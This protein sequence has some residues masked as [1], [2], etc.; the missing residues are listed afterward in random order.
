MCAQTLL[1]LNFYSSW[2][3]MTKP[4]HPVCISSQVFV[5]LSHL[6]FTLHVSLQGLWIFVSLPDSINC[7]DCDLGQC[8]H[9][10][11]LPPSDIKCTFLLLQ[12]QFIWSLLSFSWC[13]LIAPQPRIWIVIYY[14]N[15]RWAGSSWNHLFPHSLLKDCKETWLKYN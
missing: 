13:Y 4:S 1:Y 10:L 6:L 3:T 9:V 15:P 11:V 8:V 5:A 12:L 7:L 2:I 14:V